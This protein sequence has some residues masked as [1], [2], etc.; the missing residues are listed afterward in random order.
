M[1][2]TS[3]IVK[4]NSLIESRCNLTLNQQKLVLSVIAQIEK[5]DADF[6]EYTLSIIDFKRLMDI[7]ST[8]NYKTI[9]DVARDIRKKDLII[10]KEGSTL[11]TGWFSSIEIDH[12]GVIGFMID[13]KLKPYLLQLKSHFTAYQLHNILRLKSRYSVRV[14]ELLKQYQR[15]GERVFTVTELRNLLFIEPE[16]YTRFNDFKKRI[17]ETAK[18]EINQET[19]LLIDYATIKQGRTVTAIK[20]TIEY[21]GQQKADKEV[22]FEIPQEIMELIPLPE[23]SNCMD[24][25]NQIFSTYGED[26]LKFYILKTN[27]RKKDKGSYGG[28]LKTIVELNLYDDVFKAQ[29]TV[30]AQAKADHQTYLK[31]LEDDQKKQ[32]E[33]TKI[34]I[35]REALGKLKTD[36]PERY[37][38]LLNQ[39]AVIFS[40]DLKHMKRGDKLKLEFKM[41]DMM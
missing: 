18:D 34:Q 5:D 33:Q 12:K 8:G 15:I 25:V 40:I 35:K 17:L 2:E 11:I 27:S 39:A 22:V 29:E 16:K 38:D 32:Q 26:G 20:F 10:E 7:K 23:R 19:D 24:I 1:N 3:L 6:H 13:P 4:A 21:Q 41:L 9:K 36:E 31:Q 30:K 28:Y 14:Y 37:Q